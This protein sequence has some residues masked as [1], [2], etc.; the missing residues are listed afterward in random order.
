[1]DFE[2]IKVIK[3]DLDDID[4]AVSY[5]LEKLSSVIRNEEI[6]FNIRIVINEIVINSYEHGNKC[7]REKGINLKFCVNM[8]CIH[9][10]VKDEGDGINYIF[11]ENR[12]INMTTSG[13]GLRIVEH[14]VDELEINNN[15][16][17][18]KIKCETN[19]I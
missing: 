3:S 19:D 10:N 1:M 4:K 11:N 2:Y 8:D 16:I 15:E 14:L 13:R 12:D 17:R 5:V 9:I 18:A 7:N 6:M